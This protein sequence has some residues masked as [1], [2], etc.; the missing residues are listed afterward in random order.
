M[1]R[2]LPDGAIDAEGLFNAS[3]N[4][5]VV[6]DT[7]LNIVGM[8]EAYLATTMRQREALLGKN[9]F[10][11]F[12]S[13]PDSEHGIMLRQSLQRV[14]SSKR[15]EY[16]PIIPYAIARADGS[17]EERF[18]SATHTP[19]FDA[20]GEVAFVLQNT[21]DITE[22]HKLRQSA[23]GN[24]MHMQS[25]L[26]RHA[27]ALASENRLLDAER[28]HLRGL[29]VQAPSFMAVVTGPDHVFDIANTAYLKLVGDR[30]LIG[31]KARDALPEVVDQGFIELLD[32]VYSS[33]KPYVATEVKVLLKRL[34]D[35]PEEERYV[36]L[37]YQP[38]FGAD[39]KITGIFVQGHD[40]TEQR[41]AKDAA[42]ESELRF[43]SL[44]Q[45][46]P[47]HVWTSLPD[48][49]LDWFNDQ[50]YEY[51]GHRPGDLDGDKWA[52]I[53]HPDDVAAAGAA[54]QK[55]RSS[56][57]LYQ[58]EFRLRRSDGA[59]R[60]HIA[61]AVPSRGEDG[62]IIR[63]VGT[64]TDIEA[65]KKTEEQLEYLN[66]TLEDRVEERSTE[67]L[68][69]QAVLRQT[70][71][72]EA[73]GNLAGGIAHDFNNLL[74]VIG[75]NLQLVMK[76]FTGNE[77]AE[78]RLNNALSGVMRGAKLASQMLAFSRRQPLEPKV[79]NLGRLI[80]D[81]DHI[82]RR[83]IGEAI[84]IDS[85]VG[86]GLWN[87]LADPGNVEN[88]LLNLAI[89][90][91]D[92]MDG[93]GKLT[94][95]AGNAYL[96]ETYSRT[97]DEVKPGQYVMLAVSDT[98]TG[99]TPEIIEK[100][101]DPFFTTKPEGRGTG[102]GL[103]MVYGFVKQSNGHIKIYSEPGV[104]TTVKLYLPRSFQAEDILAEVDIG[105]LGGGSETILVA[106]DDEAVRETT[107]ALLSDLGYRVLKAKDAD[108]ALTIVESGVPIDLL[109][110]DVVM[111][112]RV[113]STELARA[114]KERLPNIGVL[115]TSG[116]TENSIVHGGRLDPGVQL[117]SKPYTREA[118]A[119]KVRSI[120]MRAEQEKR[121]SAVAPKPAVK[122]ASLEGVRVLLCEDDAIIRMT[123]ADMLQDMGIA[124]LEAGS[125]T[126]AMALV[127]TEF[128]HLLVT[129]VGLP[130]MSGVELAGK[131]R[132]GLPDLP[133]VFATGHSDVPGTENMPL[134]DILVKP[135]DEKGLLAAITRLIA[136][137]SK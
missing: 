101:F 72:M 60:W 92:A 17:M 73:I 15:V 21:M 91:R 27:D 135:Y 41:K 95:E 86:G 55:A 75:G 30:P 123:T 9:M 61:R 46:I 80:R 107:V 64:N 54:W 35:Q 133:V 29:F 52:A 34:E 77:L 66:A 90:A 109:F 137:I 11:A 28:E 49:Q 19:I 82:I 18:W 115:F 93:Q 106:E 114:A 69:T 129:D 44:A 40:V 31:K 62:T 59:Y 105:P 33:G 136:E 2:A 125:A 37:M 134:I 48:G 25:G 32:E 16:L 8:N 127:G 113:K 26:I 5:Y 70:Q 53:V 10:E 1:L 111:P 76:D 38:L 97:H 14:I 110:T 57:R 87:T 13:D 22:L 81:M 71:K 96:D 3:P 121:D 43:R 104:G 39:D 7:H 47:N 108:S 79:V 4:P 116:Y 126:E 23:S 42:R 65:Q 132:A 112:G 88:A 36:D 56:E 119:R 83:S 50:V 84:E 6:L 89:N 85:I 122:A 100:V 58:V 103:S 118:L 24:M 98:G 120:L 74:Q 94:I 78:R 117:L 128:V 68:E 67:L 99:M 12:P 45:S 51:S 102:L 20:A 130:D 131:I 124:V 63:W